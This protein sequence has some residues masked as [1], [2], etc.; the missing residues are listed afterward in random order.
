MFTQL[1]RFKD[2]GFFN[3]NRTATLYTPD[4]T[5]ALE[6]FAVAVTP[7][8]SDY[9]KY[10]FSSPTERAQHLDMIRDTAL[11]WRDIDVDP[12]GDRLVVL[13]TCS[14]EHED[15]RTVLVAR[16]VEIQ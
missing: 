15:A 13:S 14:F 5:Y 8:T 3:D 12:G 7:S 10:I 11:Y 2:S 1:L 6:I 4:A 9:Y 16:L